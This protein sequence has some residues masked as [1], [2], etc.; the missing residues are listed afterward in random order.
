M[1]NAYAELPF[2]SPVFHS[3]L[4]LAI[5][6]PRLL[7]T[8][9]RLLAVRLDYMGKAHKRRCALSGIVRQV[10]SLDG[11]VPCVLTPAILPVSTSK[12]PLL[13]NRFSLS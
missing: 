13:E 5:T 7:E 12:A 9:Q 8:P 10:H 11:H 2:R 3:W 4:P 6:E 1:D